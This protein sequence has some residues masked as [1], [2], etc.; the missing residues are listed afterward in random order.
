MSEIYYLCYNCRKM[1]GDSFAGFHA[2][3]EVGR[4]YC[5]NCSSNKNDLN[6]LGSSEY[7][8]LL[9]KINKQNKG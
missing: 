6:V 3:N 2:V 7:F 9:N 1:A 5:S 4:K 8:E